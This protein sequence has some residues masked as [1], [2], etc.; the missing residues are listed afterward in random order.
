MSDANERPIRSAIS[1]VAADWFMAHRAG[2]MSERERER[3]LAWL[4]ASPI[5]IE[6]YLGVAAL[7]R[8]FAEAAKQPALSLAALTELVRSEPDGGVISLLPD[9]PATR[10]ET[11]RTPAPRRLWLLPAAALC[12]ALIAAIALFWPALTRHGV[13]TQSYA[14]TRGQQGSWRLSD[15]SLLRL[16][17]DTAVTVRLSSRER[18]IDLERG[19]IALDVQHEERRPLRVRAG[20]TNAVATGTQFDVYRALDFTQITVLSGRVAVSVQDAR[21]DPRVVG[22]AA[23]QSVRITQG[24]LPATPSPVDAR[25]AFAWLERKIVF[26]RR[27]LAEVATE[28]NRYNDVALRV[29]DPTLGKLPI[30]GNFKVEDVE[31]F[32]AFLASLDGVRIERSGRDFRVLSSK[33]IEHLKM[34]A[35]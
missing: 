2:P 24:L 16:D 1:Q 33:P 26:D 9:G 28:F 6:E 10:S 25:A 35:M 30:S 23:G 20:A 7:E 3:F 31:S 18:L 8:S 4:K 34:T 14:T 17:T 12:L 11:A 29:E 27:P 32:V 15:G 19:Q 5:H 13:T 21:H 22:V